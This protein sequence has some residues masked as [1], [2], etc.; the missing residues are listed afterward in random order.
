MTNN[1]TPNAKTRQ[2]IPTIKLDTCDVCGGYLEGNTC[3]PPA[4]KLATVEDYDG[5]ALRQIFAHAAEAFVGALAG[6]AL[7]IDDE[8]NRHMWKLADDE[9]AEL[10]DLSPLDAIRLLVEIENVTRTEV[11]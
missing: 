5:V 7:G 10:E 8:D 6:I 4:V 1:T 3:C 2:L 11:A 9:H